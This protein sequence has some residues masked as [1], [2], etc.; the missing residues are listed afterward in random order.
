MAKAWPAFLELR[1]IQ[2]SHGGI[3]ENFFR[4][5]HSCK[6]V[7]YMTNPRHFADSWGDTFMRYI[8]A[9]RIKLDMI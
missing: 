4:D 5:V 2:L 8:K 7:A 3:D 9:N 1:T 6:N